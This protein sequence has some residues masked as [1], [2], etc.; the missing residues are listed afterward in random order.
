[1][2]MISADLG[3]LGES[4]SFCFVFSSCFAWVRGS[5]P[6]CCNFIMFSLVSVYAVSVLLLIFALGIPLLYFEH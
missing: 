4:F 2:I 6:T 1:M 3:L 5:C